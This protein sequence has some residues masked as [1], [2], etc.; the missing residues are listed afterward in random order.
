[1][2]AFMHETVSQTVHA[3]VQSAKISARPLNVHIAAHDI[4]TLHGIEDHGTWLV[5]QALLMVGSR[6]GVS[7]KIG[8]HTPPP[9]H[10]RA[11]PSSPAANSN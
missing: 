5:E 11:A 1:M 2:K 3:A 4:A 10:R 6:A 8:D 9:G 7:M